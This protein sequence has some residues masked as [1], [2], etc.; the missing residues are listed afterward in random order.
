MPKMPKAC[1]VR[2]LQDDNSFCTILVSRAEV[3][4]RCI[5]E[6]FTTVASCGEKKTKLTNTRFTA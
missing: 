4:A 1:S 5:H 2:P 3:C 6:R